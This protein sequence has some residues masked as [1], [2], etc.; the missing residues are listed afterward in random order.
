VRLRSIR[1]AGFKTFARPTEITFDNGVTAIVGPN[2]SGKSNI[3]D[4]IK[5]VLGERQAKEVRGRRM[6]EVIFS[7]GQRRARATEA[8]VTLVIDNSD[9]RLPID[10]QEVAI[11]RRVRREGG[12][13]YFLNN[14]RVRRHD[15]MDVLA[16]TGLTTDSYAIVDQR[17]IDGIITCTPDERRRLIEEAAQ[18]R[19]VKAKRTEA[20]LKLEALAANLTRLE[21][22]RTEI[23]PRLATVRAQA[24]VAREADQARGRLEVLRGSLAWEEWREARDTHRRATTQLQSVD[25][26]LAEARLAAEEAEQEHRRCRLELQAAQDRRLE[27]QQ[28]V[29]ARRLDLSRAEGDLALAEERLRSLTALTDAARREHG[30]LEQRLEAARTSSGELAEQ[31]A[32]AQARLAQVPQAPSPPPAGDSAQ[33]R[34]AA[35]LAERARRELAAAEAGLNE[36][37]GRQRFYE[38][39][40]VRLEPEVLQAEASL[41]GAEAEAAE[42]GR[43][44]QV[45]AQAA[46]RLARL[47][48]ELE[49]LLS[50]WPSAEGHRL[51]RVGDVVVALPGFEASLSAAL[52]PLVDA[53]AAADEPS[54]RAA[55]AGSAQ[56]ATVL[57]P[58]GDPEAEPGSL[59]ERVRCEA[60]YT[61]LARQLLGAIVMGRDVTAEGVFRQPGLLRAGADPRVALVARRGLLR[62][63][64]GALEPAAAEADHRSQLARAAEARLSEL[65]ATAG[66]RGQL[67][68]VSGHLAAAHVAGE[69]EA[70]RLPELERAAQAADATAAELRRAVDQHELALAEHRAEVRALDLE[71]SRWRD[72][73]ADVTRRQDAVAADIRTLERGREAR[74]RR[75]AE[76]DQQVAEVQA[77]LPDQRQTVAAAGGALEQ[78]ERETHVEETELAESARRLL[79]AEEA[80]IDARLKV[81]TLQGAAELHRRDADLAE[82]R[83]SELR[84]RMP[85]GKAPEEVPGGKAREREMRHLER[86]LVEIGPVNELAERECA[87]LEERYQT[88]LTQLDDITAARTD[89]ESLIGSLR[90]EEES[91]YEAVFGAVAANFAEIFT[92]LTA[93]GQATLR[94]ADGADGPRS[95]V[96]VLVQPPRKRM[97]NITLLS[98]GERA[99]TALALVVA[100]QEVN[101]APFTVLDEV[102]AALD[103]ANVGRYGELLTRLA[104]DRQF[105]VITHNHLTM[106]SAA[107][108][109]GVHLDE[110]GSSHLVSVRLEEIE[111]KSTPGSTAEQSA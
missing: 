99:L 90:S 71:R 12:S 38:E 52:G 104:R 80:R 75:A 67:D 94:H 56:Q 72:R 107:A 54:A 85:A 50:L 84:D 26:R 30:E 49:G 70:A 58:A 101:P 59:F 5:W 25:K 110:S 51:R 19:G 28:R 36:L 45:A 21:D 79:T 66:Q 83:M 37:R 6:D 16:S 42:A 1:L 95:G 74:V 77:R 27:R 73:V 17:D 2:G 24:E 18:V 32:E 34:E 10:Y 69:R 43:A 3:V 100:L 92:E 78:A 11:R 44:A 63:E 40:R 93:G 60:G 13:D 55:L 7:G 109:Y 46:S 22:L 8:E 48:A 20:A 105:M 35:R 47:N 61:R 4:A 31:L 102:D 39:A 89:L 82:A 57:Y 53:W 23:E 96:D 14:S 111:A 68:E 98:S 108:L 62:D 29:G 81:S 106:A 15:L 76:A 103:D 65:R 9:G 86:R 88:L 97:Q 91:R 41:P 33:A 64:I 87:E